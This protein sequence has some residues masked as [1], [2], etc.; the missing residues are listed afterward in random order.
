[1]AITKKCFAAFVLTLLFVM[2]FVYCS[3]SDNTSGFEI[4]Q[5]DK[6]YS[7]EPC[8]NGSEGCL[9]FCARIAYDLYGECIMKSDH[10]HYCCCVTKTK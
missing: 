4:K 2:P 10:Q 3:E 6:C 1:M 7:P 9:F 5:E 8:K